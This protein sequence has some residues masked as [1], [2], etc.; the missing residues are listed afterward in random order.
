M[1][2]AEE[3]VR[4]VTWEAPPE[5]SMRYDWTAIADQLRGNPGQWAR[6]FESDKTSIVNAIRQGAIRPLD[7]D[8]FEIRTRNN[9][10]SPERR[11]TLYMRYVPGAPEKRPKAKP[12]K[13]A[14]QKGAK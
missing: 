6:I 9:V 5:P 1:T 2:K 14:P 12:K 13:A 7:D 10:R 11:C 3:P 8:C 4:S